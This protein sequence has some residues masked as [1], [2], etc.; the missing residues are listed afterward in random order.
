MKILDNIKQ[1]SISMLLIILTAI[2]KIVFI[3]FCGVYF[4]YPIVN[5]LFQFLEAVYSITDLNFIGAL[6]E[7]GILILYL[8]IYLIMIFIFFGIKQWFRTLEVKNN[9]F[10]NVMYLW[11][12]S[13]RVWR[14]HK[15]AEYF[16]LI[17]GSMAFLFP[18]IWMI[19][20]STK[21]D[22]EIYQQMGKIVGLLP[23]IKNFKNWFEGY[24]SVIVNY[25]LWKYAINTVFYAVIILTGNIIVNSLAGYALAK[26]NFPGKNLIFTIILL[27]IILPIETTMI[28]LYT[29]VHNLRFTG[30]ILAIIIPPLVSVYNIFL[31]K[32]FFQN[33]P[34][35]LEEAAEIDG[36]NKFTIYRKII[37]PLSK[38]IIATVATF[39]FIGT[40]NDYIWPIMV[41]P[42]PSGN[43]WPLYPIQAALNTIQQNPTI[44]TMEVMSSLTL[45]TIPMI[46]F[47][48]FM[49]KYIV[50]GLST[51]GVKL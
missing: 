16:L 19:A 34:K 1:H 20:S 13:K 33:I 30:T 28:P 24:K 42:A 10:R 39:S 14:G 17:L 25:N 41:L 35:E 48:I 37:L 45:A 31:F 23:N 15:F 49:Q 40:W 2:L 47:Y 11:R 18:L 29:I 8:L 51:T 9:R 12:K 26:L 50:E 6:K 7:L 46:I 32:Q 27:L 38:P 4:I 43:E 5:I 22:Y 36:A 44:T 21:P 3:I